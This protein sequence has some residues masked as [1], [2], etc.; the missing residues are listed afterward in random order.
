MATKNPRKLDKRKA[1]ILNE[2]HKN[3]SIPIREL[4]EAVDVSDST[5]R[6]DLRQMGDA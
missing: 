3:G 5:L 1:K 4:A 6:R 2:L